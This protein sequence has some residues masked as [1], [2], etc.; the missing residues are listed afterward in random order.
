MLYLVNFTNS[1]NGNKHIQA[2]CVR[3][4]VQQYSSDRKFFPAQLVS[5]NTLLPMFV[6]LGHEIAGTCLTILIIIFFFFMRCKQTTIIV[7]KFQISTWI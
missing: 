2:T 7:L 5:Y 4:V 6:S 3:K 1:S